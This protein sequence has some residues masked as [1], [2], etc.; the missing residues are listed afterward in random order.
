[1]KRQLLIV[2]PADMIG[3]A[4]KTL[5]TSN[6]MCHL[7]NK[8]VFVFGSHS[9]AMNSAVSIPFDTS[10]S[11]SCNEDAGADSKSIIVVSHDELYLICP[12]QSSHICWWAL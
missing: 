8:Y 11:T 7:M 1:M 9:L 6:K 10:M 2:K 5:R 3:E 12:M 4:L